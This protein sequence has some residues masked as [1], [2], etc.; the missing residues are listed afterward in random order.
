MGVKSREKRERR[1][2]PEKAKAHKEAK[3]E[4]RKPDKVKVAEIYITKDSK[5]ILTFTKSIA[6]A[7]V[8]TILL[9]FVQGFL[10]QLAEVEENLPQ[11]MEQA[12]AQESKPKTTKSGIVLPS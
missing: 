9:S 4:S 10:S 5:P 6:P 11:A 1:E 3:E 12:K 7:R 2:D 8:Q